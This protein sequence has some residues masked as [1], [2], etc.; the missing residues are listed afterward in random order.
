M[1]ILLTESI[2][3]KKNLTINESFT[4]SGS[5]HLLGVDVDAD[6]LISQEKADV[7]SLK[8]SF[9]AMVDSSCD[10]CGKTVKLKVDEHFFYQLRVEEEPQMVSDYNCSDE[11]C[12]VVYLSEPVIDSNDIL[13][14]Q[15]LLALPAS[16]LC[17]EK[18]KGLCDRCGVNLNEKQCK[19]RETNENS[20]FAILK[21]LQKQKN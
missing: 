17:V 21:Q 10:R 9:K 6:F 3:N 5:Y 7:Y 18:C 11:D 4:I 14:E 1:E 16:V 8:G 12:D 13:K 19:C 15:L 20:P 2:A